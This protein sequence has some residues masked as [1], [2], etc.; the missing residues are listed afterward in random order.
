MFG[1]YLIGL[2]E[3]LEASLVVCI[4]IAYLVKTDRK[5]A[6]KPIWMG[7]GVAIALALGFG[8]A[9]EF[10]SQ[11]LT[12]EA[13]EALGG[14][15]SIV[16]VG[17]VTWMVFWMRRTARHLKSE[18]HG[19]LD[20]ALAMGTGA[21]VATAFLAV[22]REGLE[23]ALFV[24]A[25]VHAASDGTPRPLIGV[26][27]GL[28]TAVLL[29][30]LFYRGALKI[31][32]AKFFTWTGGMLV[33]VAAGVLAY[34]VHDLQEADWIPGLRNLAFDISG[35]IP[36]DSWY[37]TLLKGVLNFQPDPTVLQV[38][39]WALY[40]VPTL[41]IFLAPVGFASGKGKVKVPD[42]QGSRGSQ[43]TKAS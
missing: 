18:L 2:R 26:A 29:G 4:L 43:P 9:L 34:G 12:F 10:G 14:S 31:N 5:D 40:L 20:A 30:W 11:E 6:L 25:S 1:N 38:T 42:E 19:R 21:L 28:A 35:T 8:C 39:V 16:A 37:G 15:L 22:G 36:P 32:L 33:V 13:Q 3:G 23:T 7:I 24:W 27:L 41:A 17:L